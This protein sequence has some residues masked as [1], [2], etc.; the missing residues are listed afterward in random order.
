MPIITFWSNNEKSIGQTVSTSIVATVTAIEHNYKVLLISADLNDKV[1]ETCFGSQETNKE[2][3]KG[4]VKTNQMGLDSGIQGLLK[5]VDTNRITP[6]LIH[7][8]TRIIFKN[9]LEVLYSPMVAEGQREEKEVLSKMKNVI[10]NAARYYDYVFVDLKKGIKHNEQ[11]EILDLSD[12]IVANIDQS[13]DAIENVLKREE[14]QKMQRKMVLNI[15]RN[16]KKSKYNSKNLARKMLKKR[17]ICEIDYNTLVYDAAQEGGIPELMLRF[18][19]LKDEDENSEFALK[20]KLLIEQI[21]IKYREM[22]SG[23]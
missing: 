15:C 2:I 23:M 7:D 20:V 1:L 6:E 19:T 9:R 16:D 17:G 13:I 18:R 11:L 22:R 3:V 12:V 14:I 21:L 4:L 5:L 10:I 8:Y